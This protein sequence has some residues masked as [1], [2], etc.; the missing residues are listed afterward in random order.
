HGPRT[1]PS[2]GNG[3]RK[4]VPVISP[5]HTR[6]VLAGTIPRIRTP[7]TTSEWRDI[8]PNLLTKSDFEALSDRLGRVVR[9]QLRADIA[10]IEARM[11]L[12]E[13]ATC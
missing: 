5:I 7:A 9:A 6:Q 10:N 4:D 8:L 13:T 12:T 3:G 1:V 2:T 11:S